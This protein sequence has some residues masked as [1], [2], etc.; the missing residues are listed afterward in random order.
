MRLASILFLVSLVFIPTK[1][2][3]AEIS[4]NCGLKS[5]TWIKF[6]IEN[7]SVK[8]HTWKKEWRKLFES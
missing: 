1:L 2:S 3:A 8:I 5:G 7:K 6:D 4:I